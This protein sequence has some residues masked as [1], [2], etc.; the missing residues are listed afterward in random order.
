MGRGRTEGMEPSIRR[1]RQRLVDMCTVQYGDVWNGLFRT[2]LLGRCQGP[3]IKGRRHCHHRRDATST[4][5]QSGAAGLD[6][7]RSD[8]C[9][10]RELR[11]HSFTGIAFLLSALGCPL[12]PTQPTPNKATVY[13]R[14]FLRS[15]LS[16]PSF[17]FSIPT[18]CLPSFGLSYSVSTLFCQPVATP[19]TV[20]VGDFSL[21][22]L[23]PSTHHSSISIP[24]LPRLV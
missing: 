22:L 23:V 15:S 5:Q 4:Q 6:C 2:S 13:P 1:Q 18:W 21:K 12:T 19:S 9:D 11:C 24:Q 17:S 8:G 3:R 20:T 10:S 16:S 14:P 7:N